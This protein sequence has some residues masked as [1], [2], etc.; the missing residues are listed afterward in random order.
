[1]VGLRFGGKFPPI[2]RDHPDVSKV[3]ICDLQVQRKEQYDDGMLM[4]HVNW[5]SN[6]NDTDPF[7]TSGGLSM[8]ALFR[9]IEDKYLA[10]ELDIRT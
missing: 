10:K 2:Y 6:E 7:H 4:C 3:V 5:C 9:Y 8:N 1:M